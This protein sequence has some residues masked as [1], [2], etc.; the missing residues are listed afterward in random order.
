MNKEIK[1]SRETVDAQEI[2]S[3]DTSEEE[4]SPLELIL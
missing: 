1:D 2:P 3:I 4:Q